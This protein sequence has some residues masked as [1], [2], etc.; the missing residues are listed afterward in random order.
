MS[1]NGYRSKMAFKAGVGSMNIAEPQSAGN[2]N[3]M[4][5]ALIINGIQDDEAEIGPIDDD[6]EDNNGDDEFN[7][8]NDDL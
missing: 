5:D 8:I 4:K 2:D 3:C 6:M 7:G 1:V